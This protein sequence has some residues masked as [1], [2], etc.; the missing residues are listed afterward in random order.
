M[1][2][3]QQGVNAVVTFQK[4]FPSRFHLLQAVRALHTALI[5]EMTKSALHS[6]YDPGFTISYSVRFNG[7]RTSS[8]PSNQL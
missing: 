1:V 6:R 5:S 2:L 4:A 7:L 3:L 8:I